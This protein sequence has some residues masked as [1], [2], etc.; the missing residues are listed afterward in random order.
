V[1]LDGDELDQP[2]G[3][4]S[5]GMKRRL[6]LGISLCGDPA[7]LFLDE[8]T[9]G[10]DPESRQGVWR[11]IESAKQGRCVVLTTHSM[12]EADAL[13]TRIG[14]MAKGSLQCLGS[15]LHLKNKY[16]SG[17]QLRLRLL[18]ADREVEQIHALVRS[19]APG[20]V[21]L[22]VQ[23]G[24]QWSYVLPKEGTE[25]SCVFEAMERARVPL[26][27]GDWSLSMTSLDEV[28]ARIAERAG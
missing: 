16:G 21:C 19:L 28:F 9:T 26:G 7:I 4:L 8:P 22:G 23:P 14:I 20:M 6:S 2:A 13:C 24:A 11:V 17:F 25:I 5:G 10:L 12:E 18:D 27:I 1:G 3:Q 15:Q